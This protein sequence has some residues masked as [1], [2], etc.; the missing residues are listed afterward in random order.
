MTSWEAA[1]GWGGWRPHLGALAFLVS[2]PGLG[3]TI[4]FAAVGI[5]GRVVGR[6]GMRE[7]KGPAVDAQ[8]L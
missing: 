2:A 3:G 8:G 7:G 5:L 6:R 1:V 4:C